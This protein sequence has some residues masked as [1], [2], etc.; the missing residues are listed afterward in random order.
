MKIFENIKTKEEEK[1]AELMLEHSKIRFHTNGSGEK[2]TFNYDQI[3]TFV[4][5]KKND[6]ILIEYEQLQ[7]N[8][9]IYCIWK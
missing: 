2:M 5:N 4:K 6:Y 7:R 9:G 8:K 1:I 3:I